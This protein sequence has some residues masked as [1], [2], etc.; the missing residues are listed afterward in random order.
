MVVL[1]I[2]CM[3]AGC[4]YDRDER[5]LRETAI[6]DSLLEAGKADE[7]LAILL[8]A[9]SRID[10]SVSPRTRI[11]IYTSL[12]M[13]YYDS[14]VHRGGTSKVYV[15]KAVA[16]AREADSLS[17]LPQLLWNPVVN[18]NN[19]DS[20]VLLLNQCRDLSD[21]FGYNNLRYRSRVALASV[22]M[23]RGGFE[24]AERILDTVEA[25]SELTD[26][27]HIEL[28]LERALLNEFKG[29]AVEAVNTLHSL[30]RHHLSLDGNVNRYSALYRLER[31]LGHLDK[32]IDYKDSL[33]ACKDSINK[34]ISSENLSKVESRY[35]QTIVREEGK[36]RLVWAI[37]GVAVLLLV[38]VIAFLIKSRKMKERQVRL[39]ENISHL[40]LRLSELESS[41]DEPDDSADKID[42]LVEKFRLTRE[43]FFTLPQSAAI[44]QLN[45]TLNPE[46]ISKDKLRA[47]TDSVIGNFSESCSNLRQLVDLLTPD[48][49]LM[50]VL[51]YVGIRKDVIGVIMKVSEDAMRKRKSRIKQKL[52]SPLFELF[53]SK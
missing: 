38:V 20:I 31:K 3:A 28:T 10:E 53:F 40:N 2:A 23:R 12:A 11:Q 27:N 16:A 42:T 32:A 13:P 29:D 49:T 21:R 25:S 48:D 30:G 7:A 39:I 51:T 43:F 44:E 47:V 4:R 14:Y 52:P 22:T 37:S 17:W 15:E 36:R 41:S 5:I 33:S 9:E 19:V 6:A 1:I 24:E 8:D 45:M 35:A 18:T 50:C 46:D 34:I 26:H